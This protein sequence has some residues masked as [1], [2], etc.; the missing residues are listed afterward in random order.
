VAGEATL[1][2]GLHRPA[3]SDKYL[4][5]EDDFMLKVKQVLEANLADDE[6]GISELC[7]ELAVSHSQLYKKFKS[8]SKFRKR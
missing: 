1:F 2:S 8:P 4:Q 3:A 7:K 5:K 6:F